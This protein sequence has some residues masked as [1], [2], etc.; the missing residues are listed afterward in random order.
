MNIEARILA[1]LASAP[2]CH[3]PAS[4]L[5]GLMPG[6]RA[7]DVLATTRRLISNGRL[8]EWADAPGGPSV[9]LSSQSAAA[10]G[11][12]LADDGKLMWWA[13]AG[14]IQSR[15][16]STYLKGNEAA[17]QQL[18]PIEFLAIAPAPG[19]GRWDHHVEPDHDRPALVL[20]GSSRPAWT[21]ACE[22][23]DGDCPVCQDR[24]LTRGWMCLGCLAMS[25]PL[26][27]VGLPKIEAPEPARRSYRPHARL[28]GGRR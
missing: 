6:Q 7:G 18:E 17:G 26:R 22:A 21:P 14:S 10:L 25:A 23:R 2:P 12:E 19:E 8:V 13:R 3:I 11:L 1:A 9:L 16:F 4:E 27:D 20:I 15:T 28:A 5:P 24:P